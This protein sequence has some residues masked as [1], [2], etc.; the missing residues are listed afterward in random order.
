[1]PDFSPADITIL[2]AHGI[3]LWRDR[4]IFDAQPPLSTNDLAAIQT[5]CNGPLPAELLALWQTTSGGA[6][7]YDLWAVMDDQRQAIGWSEL[8]YPRSQ[9]YRDLFGWIEHELGLV[10]EAYE[11][12]GKPAPDKLDVLP[13]GGFEYC[14]RVYVVV[15]PGPDYGTVHVWKHGLPPAWRHRLHADTAAPLATSLNEAFSLLMLERDPIA[16]GSGGTA[17]DTCRQYLNERCEA[18]GLPR[19][20]ANAVIEVFRAAVADWRTPL[21]TRK[22]KEAPDLAAVAIRLAIDTDDADLL[23]KIARA[24]GDLAAPL[25]GDATPLACALSSEKFAAAAAILDESVFVPADILADLA[26]PAPVDLIALLLQRGASPTAAAAVTCAEYDAPE[27]ARTVIRALRA[28]NRSALKE[29]RVERDGKLKS[30][31]EDLEKVRAGKF[32]HYLGEAGLAAHIRNLESFK[33]DDSTTLL[34]VRW[35]WKRS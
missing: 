19:E 6:M 20:L 33:A 14:D 26:G 18:H 5:W 10:A 12:Q 3:V 17:G 7:D 4:V 30:L 21:A 31:R 2:R 35:P 32:G 8:F 11:E 29:F 28:S 1:M 16:P 24:G 15:R 34:G 25:A 23:R 13:I 22:L 9:G 27:S